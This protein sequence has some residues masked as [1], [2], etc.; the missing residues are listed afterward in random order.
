MG[1]PR[2]GTAMNEAAAVDARADVPPVCKVVHESGHYDCGYV[3]SD[4]SSLIPVWQR[5]SRQE[6]I[7][8]SENLGTGKEGPSG[9]ERR[10]RDTEQARNVVHFDHER[11]QAAGVA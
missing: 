11:Q 1:A 3:E 2:H 9:R 6:R 4:L 5:L 8:S 7:R 10:R